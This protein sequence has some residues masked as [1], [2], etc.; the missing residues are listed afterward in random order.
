MN[1]LPEPTARQP[2]ATQAG[3]PTPDTLHQAA[4]IAAAVDAIYEQPTSYRNDSLPNH[5]TIGTTP[6]VPQPG[7]PPMSEAA[8]N[9]SGVMV[10]SSLPILALGGAATGILWASG[11]ADPAVVGCIVAAP[12]A[13]AIP[14]LALSRLIKRAKETVEAAPP[15]IHQHYNGTVHQD[16]RTVNSTNRGIWASTRNQLPAG[17]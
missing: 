12:A 15:V 7:K 9:L 16:A 5:S 11:H 8:A 17:E 2:H 10:A 1:R 14:I 13:L 6:P 4:Q 3:Q